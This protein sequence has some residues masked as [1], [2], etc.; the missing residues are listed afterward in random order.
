[1]RPLIENVFSHEAEDQNMTRA[2]SSL[3]Q[4]H[5]PFLNNLKINKQRHILGISYP[6]WI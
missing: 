5:K 3:S 1:M 4:L 2:L 6:S